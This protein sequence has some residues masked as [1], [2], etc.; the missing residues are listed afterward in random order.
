MTHLR[1]VGWPTGQHR[2]GLPAAN[3][4]SWLRHTVRHHVP[5]SHWSNDIN[6]LQQVAQRKTKKRIG[7]PCSETLMERS[8]QRMCP[9][10]SKWP[11][12]SKLRPRPRALRSWL[13]LDSFDWKDNTSRSLAALNFVCGHVRCYC[14]KCNIQIFIYNSSFSFLP[15]LLAKTKLSENKFEL[16]IMIKG[17]L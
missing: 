14:T 3:V 13:D 12:S 16:K 4:D 11:R 15:K 9:F 10:G 7:R 17:K 6:Y 5:I 2:A 8:G 1:Q